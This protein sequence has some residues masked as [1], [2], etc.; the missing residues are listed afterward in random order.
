MKQASFLTLITGLLLSFFLTACRESKPS[1]I[2]YTVQSSSS[3]IEWKGSAPDHFHT[4]SFDVTGQITTSSQ[5]ELI[6][7]NFTIPIASIDNYDLQGELKT[8]LLDHLKSP[9][10]FYLAI[11]PYARFTLTQCVAL[12]ANYVE[13]GAISGANYKITG[14]FN[15]LGQTH[16]ITFPAKIKWENDQMNVN[17]LLKIDRTQWGM[18][19]YNDP[20]GDLY[21]YPD[22]ELQLSLQAMKE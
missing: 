10:F 9:E 8:Q 15:M 11:Y 21:I 16:P 22:V 6:S 12:P 17:A 5:R 20:E 13:T 1:E 19:M 4:G 3:K 7:A 18:T 2:G 14:N